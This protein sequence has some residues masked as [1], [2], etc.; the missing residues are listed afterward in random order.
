MPS[1]EARVQSFKVDGMTC[2]HCVQA[3]TGAVQTVDPGSLVEVDLARGRV[4]VEG[5]A[6][7]DVVAQAIAAE[8]YAAE[9]VA[10]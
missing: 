1:R 9:P 2:A 10:D 4:R 7:P 5:G 6:A 3:V 8:G